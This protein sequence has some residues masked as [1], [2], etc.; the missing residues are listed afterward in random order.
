MSRKT[1]G[2]QCAVFTE[3]THQEDTGWGGVEVEH[4]FDCVYIL[5]ALL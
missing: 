1:L 5:L 3:I 4:E 2:L